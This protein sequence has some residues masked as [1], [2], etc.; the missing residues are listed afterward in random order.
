[1]P[2]LLTVV[3]VLTMTFLLLFSMRGRNIWAMSAGPATLVE[4]VFDRPEIDI[5]KA[6]SYPSI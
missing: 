2:K 6:V 3:E 4:N 1:L 5:V